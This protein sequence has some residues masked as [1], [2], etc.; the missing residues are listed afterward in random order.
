MKKLAEL[1]QTPVLMK[2][3]KFGKYKDREIAEIVKADSG[4]INWMK[5]NMDLDEDML[6]TLEYY[7]NA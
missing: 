6:H 4:Y 7:Q 2:T 5:N 1:T 3:F